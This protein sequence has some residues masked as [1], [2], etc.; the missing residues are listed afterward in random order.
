MVLK[1]SSKCER[2]GLLDGSESCY[3]ECFGTVALT[4]TDKTEL[5]MLIF[6]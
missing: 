1:E 2:E 5:K 6:R 4:K 3:D